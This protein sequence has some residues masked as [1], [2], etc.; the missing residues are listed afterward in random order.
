MGTIE[1]FVLGGGCVEMFLR[2]IIFS[3]CRWDLRGGGVGEGG[4]FLR[5]FSNSLEEGIIVWVMME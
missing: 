4:D 3:L 5:V 2:K 1:V